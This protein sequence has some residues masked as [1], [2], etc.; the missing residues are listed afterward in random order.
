MWWGYVGL[1]CCR[2]STGGTTHSF[3]TDIETDHVTCVHRGML[4]AAARLCDTGR[5]AAPAQTSVGLDAG[6]HMSH[7]SWLF[8][9]W[10]DWVQGSC[11]LTLL[12]ERILLTTMMSAPGAVLT[13]LPTKLGAPSTMS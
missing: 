10:L 7:G 5:M 12:P 11:S 9:E 8:G 3:V 2:E 6:L 4:I 1:G 13:A